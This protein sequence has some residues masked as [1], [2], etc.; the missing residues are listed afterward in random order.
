MSNELAKTRPAKVDV[1]IRDGRPNIQTI[2]QAF[3]VAD[4]MVHAGWTKLGREQACVAILHG[5]TLGLTPFQSVQGI[6]VINGRPTLW[7][8][9][10][11]AVVLAS[12]QCE[13][14]DCEM[15]GKGEERVATAT[16]GRKGHKPIQRTFSVADAKKAGLW[17]KSGPWTHYP[18]RMLMQRARAFALR[19]AFADLLQGIQIREEVD[20]YAQPIPVVNTAIEDPDLLADVPR[21]PH[22]DDKQPAPDDGFA[23]EMT[24]AMKEQ[25]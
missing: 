24:K 15:S 10:L 12:G 22:E 23:D 16:A 5:A 9:A 18:E 3:R 19:D 25:M 13:A 11:V 2:E 20:D 6:A 7:G 17:G 4:M 1:A 21:E 14:C 8:D